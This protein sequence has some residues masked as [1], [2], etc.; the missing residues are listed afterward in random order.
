MDPN[1]KQQ[2]EYAALMAAMEAA[3]KAIVPGSPL[4]DA[5]AAAVKAIEVRI[6]G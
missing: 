6:Q 1:A 3:V 4:C 2:E 5:Y